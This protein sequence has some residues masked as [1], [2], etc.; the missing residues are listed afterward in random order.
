MRP[1]RAG[2][3]LYIMLLMLHKDVSET[4]IQHN[5]VLGLIILKAYVL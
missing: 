2:S 1:I 4:L 5:H 3:Y